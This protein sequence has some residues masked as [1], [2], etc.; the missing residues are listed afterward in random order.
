MN[1]GN[2]NQQSDYEHPLQAVA[3]ILASDVAGQLAQPL[4]E[5]REKLAVM[6]ETLDRYI[7]EADGPK[8]YPWKPLQ[9]LRQEIGDTYLI[10]RHTTRLASE[11]F[12]AVNVGTGP[13]GGP[14][15]ELDINQR[16]EI[17][18]ELVRHRIGRQTELFVD[19]GSIPPVR[20][21]A[22]EITL[23]VAKMLIGCAD[24][25]R[26]REGSAISVKTRVE[27]VD[28]VDQVVIYTADNGNGTPAA[29]ESAQR[30]IAPLMGHLG[31]SFHAISE[32]G[33]GSVFECRIP[34]TARSVSG[35]AHD[36]SR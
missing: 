33:Q 3:G 26:L 31:G 17:A 5:L 25:A 19:L 18:L 15:E 22:G 27:R 14:G 21:S 29:A 4:R 10:A 6:V 9:V 16:V 34:V 8:P 12:E 11:L 36:S 13:V 7:G 35:P 1:S 30:A 32:P 24:S 2:R 20:A 28:S 23:A